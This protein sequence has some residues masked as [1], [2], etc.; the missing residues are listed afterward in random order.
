MNRSFPPDRLSDSKLGRSS[1]MSFLFVFVFVFVSNFFFFFEGQR[2]RISAARQSECCLKPN[3]KKMSKVNFRCSTCRTP[4]HCLYFSWRNFKV[5][6]IIVGYFL[7]LFILWDT[8]G[9]VLS[10]YSFNCIDRNYGKKSLILIKHWP[11]FN[12]F[13]ELKVL[14]YTKFFNR[15]QIFFVKKYFF[16]LARFTFFL[17]FQVTDLAAFK[18]FQG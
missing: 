12:L 7:S 2:W 11:N 6:S 5:K 4:D 16:W 3:R 10:F 8:M 13:L 15:K 17:V 1:S 9:L 18:R 14:L